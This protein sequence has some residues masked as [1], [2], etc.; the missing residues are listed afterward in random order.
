MQNLKFFLEINA[1]ILVMISMI[2]LL[3]KEYWA[4]RVFKNPLY[5][6]VFV[7]VLVLGL[8]TMM[9]FTIHWKTPHVKGEFT[10]LGVYTCAGL[11]ILLRVWQKK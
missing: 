3:M 2:P 6:K 8:Y 7:T 5:Q 11:S 4:F 10:L 9:L 1:G